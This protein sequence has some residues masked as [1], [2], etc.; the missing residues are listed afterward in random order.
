MVGNTGFEPV[1]STMCFYFGHNLSQL[2]DQEFLIQ[3]FRIGC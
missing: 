1:T 2:L 3:G